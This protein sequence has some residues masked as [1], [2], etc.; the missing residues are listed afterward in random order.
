[1]LRCG[2][3]LYTFDHDRATL[4]DHACK[5]VC[6]ALTS[7]C[8]QEFF[9]GIAAFSREQILAVNGHGTE[10]WGWGKEGVLRCGMHASGSPKHPC[11]HRL[12]GAPR[13]QPAGAL[14][15][16]AALAPAASDRHGGPGPGVV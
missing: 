14:H 16:G 6:S 10:F 4:A 11:A 13:R 15:A 2:A 8:P 12:R 7:A 5:M 3:H 1:M 9:G